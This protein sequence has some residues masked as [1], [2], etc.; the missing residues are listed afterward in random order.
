MELT[1]PEPSEIGPLIVKLVAPSIYAIHVPVDIAALAASHLDVGLDVIECG[2]H[3]PIGFGVVNFH[4]PGSAGLAYLVR[5]GVVGI[6]SR[7]SVLGWLWEERIGRLPGS[8]L[9]SPYA[10]C[11]PR[12]PSP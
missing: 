6:L 11:I 8:R 10:Y 4:E 1:L 2:W 3:L 7:L 5:R 12:R 9:L